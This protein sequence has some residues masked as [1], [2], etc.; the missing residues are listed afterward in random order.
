MKNTVVLIDANVVITYITGR[1]DPYKAASEKLM[2]LCSAER[3]DG[4]L[5]FHSLSVIWYVLRKWPQS[6]RRKWLKTICTVLT[7]T[8][9]SQ[10]EILSAIENEAFAD[11][12][13]CLQDKCAKTVQAD[14]IVTGNI[15]D[16]RHSEIRAVTPDELLRI[17]GAD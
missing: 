12:E 14:Y 3:I 8:G 15:R 17:I 6:R 2:E 7:V 16:Y 9:A 5:A 11:F 13:D 4:Y 1:D 10:A